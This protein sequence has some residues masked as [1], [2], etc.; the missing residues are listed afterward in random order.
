MPAPRVSVLMLTFNRPQ[1]ISRAIESVRAQ[2]FAAWELLVVHDGPDE[3]IAR[4]VTAWQGREPRLRYLRRPTPGNIAEANNYGLREARGEYIAILDD[5]D[6]WRVPDKLERQ[7][8]FLDAHPDHAA[9]GGGAVCIDARGE[10]TLRYLK[11]EHHE[12]IVRG[13]LVA[14]PMIHSTTLYRK[15]AAAGAGLYDESL[16]GYQDWDFWLKLARIGRLYNFQEYFLAYQI[17]EGGGT[18]LAQRRN[19]ACAVRIVRRHGRHYRGYPLALALAG[20]A[21][22]HARMPEMVK[23]ATFEPLNR[24]KKTLF[25]SKRR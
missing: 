17:W 13:A 24:L 5:D 16:A 10:E 8:A 6:F 4:I 3:E 22:L 23:K 11:P 20:A 25:A 9:C 19:T 1:F 2:T 7:A 15:A 12:A 21:Y 18:Y 14:N